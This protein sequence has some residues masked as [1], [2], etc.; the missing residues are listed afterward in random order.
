MDL[1]VH[2]VPHLEDTLVQLFQFLFK[3]PLHINKLKITN[4]AFVPC[5]ASRVTF[6][7]HASRVTFLSKPSRN[8]LLRVLLIRCG[9]YF[10]GFPELDQFAQ[11]KKGGE[12]AHT[13][14][15][16]HVM[17]HNDDGVILL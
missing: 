11:V 6:F 9:K 4:Y 13:G 16:L 17:G 3:M 7:C 1:I 10:P 5:H 2:Q 14:S 15:L 8:I 12:V